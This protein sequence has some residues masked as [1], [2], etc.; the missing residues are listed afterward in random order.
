MKLATSLTNMLGEFVAIQKTP[1][2]KPCSASMQE[3]NRAIKEE[4][5]DYT[6]KHPSSV[7]IRPRPRFNSVGCMPQE[8]SS[9]PCGR[10]TMRPTSGKRRDRP[11]SLVERIM[12]RISPARETEAITEE[13]ETGETRKQSTQSEKLY[14]TIV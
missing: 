6:L 13:E 3:L 12:Q 4:K 5:K 10:V 1:E 9:S 2:F 7:R 11:S 14:I 8:V